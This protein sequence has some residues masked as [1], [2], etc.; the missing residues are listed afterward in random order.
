VGER[1]ALAGPQDQIGDAGR[2]R[3][4]V[5]AGEAGLLRLAE[6]VLG[7]EVLDLAEVADRL[8]HLRSL[9]A[10]ARR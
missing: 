6:P 4:E 3:L 2:L 8:A 5:A 10:R 1:L 7:G 9:A